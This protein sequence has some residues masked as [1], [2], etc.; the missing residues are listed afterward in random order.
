M[1]NSQN[2]KMNVNKPPKNGAFSECSICGEQYEG[3]GNN[4]QPINNG[5]CCDMCNTDVIYARLGLFQENVN[6]QETFES[7][8]ITLESAKLTFHSHK[9]NT[10]QAKYKDDD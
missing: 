8:K 4:A 6:A 7:G 9:P 5:I 1:R 10:I 3:F 2:L